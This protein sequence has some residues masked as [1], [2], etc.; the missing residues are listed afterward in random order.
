MDPNKNQLLEMMIPSV[1]FCF[2]LV[3]AV[4]DLDKLKL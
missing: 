2:V 1:L 3:V 4:T